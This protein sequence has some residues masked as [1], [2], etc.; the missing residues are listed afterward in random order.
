MAQSAAVE[1]F[2]DAPLNASQQLRVVVVISIAHAL[3]HFMHLI[4]PPVFPLLLTEFSLSYSELGLLMTAFFVVSGVVQ[5]ASGFAVDKYGPLPVLLVSIALFALSTLVLA[6]AQ[7][8]SMLLLGSVIAGAGNAPFHPVDYCILNARIEGKRLPRSYAVHGVAGSLGWAVAPLLLVAVSAL[9]GWRVAMLAA[10]VV[11]LVIW[12]LVWWARNELRVTPIRRSP[13][14]Q[15]GSSQEVSQSAWGFMRLPGLWISFVYFFGT[16]FAIGGVQSF[17]P[18]S[19]A[20]LHEIP[21]THVALLVSVYMIGSAV[22]AL[23][24]GWTMGEARQAERIVSM[25]LTAALCV[26]LSIAYL[27]TPVWLSTMLFG[28]MG[29]AAGVGTPARDLLVKRAAPPGATGRIYGIIY[30]GLDVGVAAA[31]ALFGVIMDA[32]WPRGVWI[33]IALAYVLMIVCA[34]LLARRSIEPTPSAP[35]A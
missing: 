22:G 20:Q 7:S 28:V 19:A 16:A 11:C 21:A 3:S 6:S 13:A 15:P 33:G 31:P 12:A 23:A 30:A 18:G 29:F 4:L 14:L 17:G 26:A 27:D 34:N 25:A 10:G 8:Y 5:A 9:A 1:A 2:S 35:G 32:R 24:G